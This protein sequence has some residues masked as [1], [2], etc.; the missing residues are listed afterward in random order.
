[1]LYVTLCP[2]WQSVPEMSLKQSVHVAKCLYQK[3][4]G[5][6][7]SCNKREFP[8]K[9]KRNLEFFNCS[10]CLSQWPPLL[11]WT[12]PPPISCDM[13]TAAA[14][15]WSTF[16][17]LVHIGT[18]LFIVTFQSFNCATIEGGGCYVGH[19]MWNS[20]PSGILPC[21][22]VVL[23]IWNDVDVSSIF[24]LDSRPGCLGG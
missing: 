11:D 6:K 2:F 8:T 20:S 22:F 7:M 16:D 15:C 21:F 4:S 5:T 18:R 9:Q 24:L 1:M 19:C 14:A 10:V 3:I 17:Q 23:H 13:G 12:L